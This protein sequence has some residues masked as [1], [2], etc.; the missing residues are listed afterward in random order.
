MLVYPS[1]AP[2]SKGKQ[3]EEEKRQKE[4]MIKLDS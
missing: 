4:E 1:Y 2:K 3:K